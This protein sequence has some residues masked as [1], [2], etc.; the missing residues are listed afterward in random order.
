MK[1]DMSQA[2]DIP[3]PHWSPNQY[4]PLQAY[5][6]KFSPNGELQI[7]VSFPFDWTPR[8]RRPGA[9]LFFGGGWQTGTVAQFSRHAAYLA[10]RGMVAACADYR[11]KERHDATPA[12]GVEDARSAVRWMRRRAAGLGIDPDRIVGGGGSAGAH[13]AACA[14]LTE[15]LDAPGDDRSVSGRPDV[16]VLFNP[17]MR[18]DRRRAE[19]FG[20]SD[21]LAERISPVRNVG[22]NAPPSVQFFGGD[23]AMLADGREFADACRAAGVRADFHVAPEQ[24]HGFFNR[25][26]WFKR[27]LRIADEFL[28]SLGYLTG[29][30]LV[31][32]AAR[33]R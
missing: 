28:T 23:D 12:D 14:A 29:P 13:L 5:T 25:N 21:D 6:Y 30:P 15:G 3:E 33:S 22:P 31:D 24:G 2:A 27:T 26:P 4:R 8:D 10:S 17:A 9:V 11:V 1:D 7:H 18:I 16:L 32:D 20:L 19:R